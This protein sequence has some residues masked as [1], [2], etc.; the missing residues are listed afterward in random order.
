VICCAGL[1]GKGFAI[2]TS[3]GN[4]MLVRGAVEKPQELHKGKL[5]VMF[6]DNNEKR[7][8]TGG[9]DGVINLLLLQ[10]TGLVLKGKVITLD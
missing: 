6:F 3:K 10:S 2:G 1:G 8:F 9:E 7:L 4:L 5:Y